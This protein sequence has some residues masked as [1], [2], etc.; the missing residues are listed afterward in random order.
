MQTM[1]VLFAALT[2]TLVLGASSGDGGIPD[3]ENPAV[4]GR[5]KEPG[6]CTLVPYSGGTGP[7]STDLVVS[8]NGSWKF[9]WVRKPADR[10]ADFYKP[11]YDVSSWHEIPVPANC[12]KAGSPLRKSRP[13]KY[14][15]SFSKLPPSSL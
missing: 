10:P 13:V 11:Q 3:W 15:F 4:V 8:L 6:H 1:T 5:N 12:L 14:H 2:V 7:E 9:R